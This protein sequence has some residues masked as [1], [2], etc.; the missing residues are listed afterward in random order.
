M[1]DPIASAINTFAALKGMDYQAQ[2]ADRQKRLDEERTEDRVLQRRLLEKQETRADDEYHHTLRE[3]DRGEINKLLHAR[4]LQADSDE[5]KLDW[6]ALRADLKPFHDKGTLPAKFGALFDTEHLERKLSGTEE[7]LRQLHTGQLDHAAAVP[8]A[9]AAF[10]DELN[11]RG[12]RYGAQQV[13]IREILPSPDGKGFMFGADVTLP[14]GTTY[15]APLTENGGTAESGDNA[16]KVF[17]AQQTIDYL[18]SQY[19]TLSGIK[20]HLLA[21]GVIKPPELALA[22]DAESGQILYNKNSGEVVKRLTPP[23]GPKRE[24]MVAGSDNAGRHGIDKATGEIVFQLH[25]PLAS[26]AG[27]GRGGAGGD[28]DERRAHIYGQFNDAL[29]NSMIAQYGIDD[30]AFSQD[31]MGNQKIDLNRYLSK[32]PPAA[33]QRY[34]QAKAQGEALMMRGVPPILAA[35]EAFGPYQPPSGYSQL[36][37]GDKQAIKTSADIV[38]RGLHGEPNAKAREQA[39]QRFLQSDARRDVKEQVLHEYEANQIRQQAEERRRQRK[40]TLQQQEARGNAPENVL[41]QGLGVLSRQPAAYQ[42]MQGVGGNWI[43]FRKWAAQHHPRPDAVTDPQV[44]AA[45]AKVNPEAARRITQAANR[46]AQSR[47]VAP[48]MARFGGME[49]PSLFGVSR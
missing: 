3:R 39:L 38:L 33:K 37:G 47:T 22:G 25:G 17:P 18:V 6:T 14:D 10:S 24:I 49:A 9:N 11:A 46:A 8:A 30:G 19:K 2:Q 16:V 29:V 23:K 4:L 40:I 12:L 21:E 1:A 32:L 41:K 15:A 36:P 42:G 31:E 44:L 28:L 27:G 26:A 35:Q 20:E 48:G 34:L 5:S 45:F 43:A 13:S 7:L